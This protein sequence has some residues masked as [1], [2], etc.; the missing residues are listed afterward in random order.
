MTPLT[1]VPE[2]IEVHAALESI[3]SRWKETPYREG[4]SKEGVGVDCIRYVTAGL[5]Q[6]YRRQRMPIPRLCADASMHNLSAVKNLARFL[7]KNY[8]T[9]TI[10][11]NIIMPGDIICVKRGILAGHALWVGTRKN[12]LWHA[13][14]GVGVCMTG[15]GLL[16]EEILFVE[17][18]KDKDLWVLSLA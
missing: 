17:R 6:L 2:S 8:P 10:K 9:E 13:M 16:T 5:D 12:T 7:R 18:P 15:S 14:K 11:D 1:W 4:F 3:Y